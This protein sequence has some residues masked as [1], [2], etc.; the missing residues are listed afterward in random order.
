MD[1]PQSTSTPESL[2]LRLRAMINSNWITQALY[3]TA[4][5]GL[6]DFLASGPQTSEYLAQATGVHA[7]SL[8][9]LL[10][11]LVT[12]DIVREREEG[13]FALLPLGALL[14]RDA[15]TSLRSW[16]ILVGGYHWQAWGHLLDS[17]KTGESAQVRH[18][19][20]RHGAWHPASGLEGLTHGGQPPRW[21]VLWPCRCE[22][23]EAC[24]V[25]VH[26]A[27]VCVQDA[28]LRRW[29]TAHLGEPPERGRAP[30][31]PARGA[32]SGSEHEGVEAQRGVRAIAAGRRT[33]ARALTHGFL[34]PLGDRDR[35]EVS[36]ASQAGQLPRVSAVRCDPITGLCR[37]STYRH[38][39]SLC[40]GLL[41]HSLSIRKRRRGMRGGTMHRSA[42]PDVADKGEHV[43]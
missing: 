16:A 7:P 17:V 9:R 21:P 28:V 22:T 40:L 29:G 25:C 33:G 13:D 11:A 41:S 31:G 36:C 4:Q 15:A 18:Q 32:E 19:G 12:I 43:W 1:Q 35:G 42:P 10:R 5:L 27:D 24:G 14:Q 26:R 3:V 30:V 38:W 34:V 37:G 39:K 6:P 20:D 8:R 23:L 2:A